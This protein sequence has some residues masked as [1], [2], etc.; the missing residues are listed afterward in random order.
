M[1]IETKKNKTIFM[2]FFQKTDQ[3]TTPSDEPIENV[4]NL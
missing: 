4:E 2:S 3:D 1:K